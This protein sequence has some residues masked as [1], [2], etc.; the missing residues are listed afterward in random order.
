MGI[1]DHGIPKDITLEL[2]KLSNIK[3][4]IETGT[5]LGHT[6]RWASQYFECVFTVERSEKL[7]YAHAKELAQIKGV[8]PLLGDS[9]E[10]LPTILKKI[11]E[12]KAIFWLD[13]HWSGGETY[14]IDDECPLLDELDILGER[15]QDIILIDDARLFLSAPPRPHKVNQWPTIR[16]IIKAPS[17]SQKESYIQIIDD[18]IFCVPNEEKLRLHLSNYA[19]DR[20]DAF[21]AEFRRYQNAPTKKLSFRY[22]LSKI[23]NRG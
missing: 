8:T 16:D 22:I 18:V 4:F 6:T 12:Q 11:G 20:A 14:G 19:Q 21:W 10:V 23:R 3:V 17:V 1:V 5:Y 7:F 2:A 9:R 15:T 13:G